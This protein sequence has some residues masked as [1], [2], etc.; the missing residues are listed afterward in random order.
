MNI[1][2]INE[3]W[4]GSLKLSFHSPYKPPTIQGVVMRELNPLLDGRG[5]VTEL[6]SLPWVEKFGLAVPKHVYQSATDFGV[7][8]AWH[9]HEIHTDQFTVTRGKLQVS[10]VDVRED[11]STFGHVNTLF[12]GTIRPRLIKIPPLVMHGW[13]AL[14]APEVLVVNLQTETY[15][16]ADE[17]K[18]RWDCID[19]TIWQPQHG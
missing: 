8:K 7:I 10:L 19:P 15:D 14:T 18:Y 3:T 17:F 6:W 2:N 9:M 12:L 1:K 16:P 13:K 11:S 4:L 5:E